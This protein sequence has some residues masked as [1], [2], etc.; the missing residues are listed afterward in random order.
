MNIVAHNILAM[1]AQRQLGI[2]SKSKGTTIERLSSGYKV[3]R[4]AD[5]AA[6]LSISEK[7]RLQIRG[8]SKGIENAQDGISMCQVADG[9]LAEVD[10]MLHRIT[11]LS[12]K[13]ANGTLSPDD[14]QDIQKE[15][16]S[17]V[18]EISRVGDTTKFN[19][20]YVFRGQEIPLTNLDGTPAVE[21]LIPVSDFTLTDVNLGYTPFDSNS[22]G[23]FL[24]LKAIVNNS[25]S[26]FNGK[27][28]NLIYGNGSTSSSSIRINY[29]DTSNPGST[30]TEEVALRDMNVSDYSYNSTDQIWSRKFSYQNVDGVDISI[31]QQVGID[32]SSAEEKK[33]LI[34][35]EITN[36]SNSMEVTTQFMFH[37]DTAYNNNDLCEGYFVDANRIEEI[38]IYSESNSPF[39][40]GS[41]SP[42]V[43]TG[44][45][46]SFSIVDV[47][48]ALAFSE[49]VSFDGGT[50]PD[51]LSI[52]VY[53]AIDAWSYYTN[54]Q[55]NT[56]SML[57]TNAINQD[58]GFSLLWDDSLSA[59]SHVNY[60]FS[61]GIIAT[62]SDQ[63]L[64]NVDI[65]RDKTPGAAGYMN[66]SCWI[67]TGCTAHDGL[68]LNIDRMNANV[69]GID[70][71]DVTTIEG[72]EKAIDA[73]EYALKRVTSNRSNIGAQQNRLEHII[74]NERNIVENTTSAESAIRDTDMA[75]ETVQLSKDNILEQ[76]GQ[77][78]LAQANQ[79]SQ[80]VLSLLG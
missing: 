54:T 65:N 73:V 8:L 53:S 19:E 37:V 50:K 34:N 12:V 24:S 2:N 57:G 23:G 10:D 74:N 77:A 13:S 61:Y 80:G 31:T 5:D 41:T 43:Q 6:N 11:E 63:N 69:L 55:T 45:P 76:V 38:G 7:M 46:D 44:V 60:S 15:I 4:A 47:D 18:D 16:Q 39:T 56:N 29:E 49:K 42:H 64:T 26:A 35:Y 9:A 25:N 52:G 20:C 71:L 59:S 66:Y 51:S 40:A 36:N 72:A 62:E 28:Y 32:E 67:Q 79:S 17:L 27:N 14:R 68:T 22:N 48:N 33:Y 78:I 1:N 3:N 21:G 58:L 70:E 75:K 30:K